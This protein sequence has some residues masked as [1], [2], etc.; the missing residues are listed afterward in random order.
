M[1][2]RMRLG[3]QFDTNSLKLVPSMTGYSQTHFLSVYVW[4]D[5]L[6]RRTAGNRRRFP[7]K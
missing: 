4:R 6:H 2:R 5:M 3:D 7:E 1:G